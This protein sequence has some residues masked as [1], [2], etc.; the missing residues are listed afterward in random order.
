MSQR[1]RVGSRIVRAYGAVGG[2]NSTEFWAKRRW[3][4]FEGERDDLRDGHDAAAV[5]GAAGTGRD[6][7]VALS[8]RDGSRLIAARTRGGQAAAPL[9]HLLRAERHGHGVLD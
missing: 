2:I 5:N 7:R 6:A 8:R 1:Y 9:P 4:P 3:N